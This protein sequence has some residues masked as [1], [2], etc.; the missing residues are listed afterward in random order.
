MYNLLHICR[1][2]T[3]MYL[4]IYRPVFVNS[5]DQALDEVRQGKHWGVMDFHANYST[6]LYDRFFGM[7]EMKQ[8]STF[9]IVLQNAIFN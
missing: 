6:A 3:L 8:V 9:K 1:Y 5:L 2:S 7:M 4:F